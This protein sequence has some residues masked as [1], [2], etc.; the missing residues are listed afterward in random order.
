MTRTPRRAKLDL[1]GPYEGRERNEWETTTAALVRMHPLNPK[2]IVEVVLATWNGIFESR[3]G[4]RGFRLGID[5]RPKP[6]IMGHYLHELIPLEFQLRYPGQW[7]RESSKH[8]KD[9]VHIPD[10]RFSVEIKSSSHPTQIFGNR[11]YGQASRVTEIGRKG[12]S[13]YY[14][15][16]NF[17]KFGDSEVLPHI[18]RIRFGWLDLSDWRSQK[19]ATGQ[20]ANLEPFSERTK[21]L[22]IYEAP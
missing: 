3:I 1:T 18:V 2:E 16:I 10:V 22:K 15:A 7:R 6:Q 12:K 14:L 9:L 5:I 8:E 21:L 4:D 20:Q 13:G 19:S 11:S 17:A